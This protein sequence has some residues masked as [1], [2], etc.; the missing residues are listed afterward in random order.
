MKSIKTLFR[1][2]YPPFFTEI[3]LT[4]YLR[5]NLLVFGPCI[6][7]TEGDHHRKFRKIMIPAFSTTNLRKMVPMFYE[8]VQRV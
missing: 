2:P 6:L 5:M 7:S 8:V 3:L 4:A 1:L